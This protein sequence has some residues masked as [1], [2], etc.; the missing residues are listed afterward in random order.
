MLIDPSSP[1]SDRALRWFAGLWFPALCVMAGLAARRHDALL[2]AYLAWTAGAL[3]SIAGLMRPSVVRPIYRVL[4]G[5]TYPIGWVTSHVLLF[6][7]YYV[8][9]TPVGVLVRMFHDPMG[10][11][12]DRA[13]ASYWTPRESPQPGR[14]FR[15]F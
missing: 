8:V 13:E 15:Q 10:R 5:V 12:L 2:V 14:Y 6:V 3:L 11:R 4:M 9:I 1:V 7:L